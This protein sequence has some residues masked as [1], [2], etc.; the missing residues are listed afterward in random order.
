MEKTISLIELN[1]A[2]GTFYI[3]KMKSGDLIKISKTVSRGDGGVQREESKK[4]VLDIANYCEDPDATFPTPIII[5]VSEKNVLGIRRL[6]E[7]ISSRSVNEREVDTLT[8]VLDSIISLTYDDSKKI[9]EILDGQHRIRGIEKAKQ[10]TLDLPIVVMFDLTEEEKAYV[11]STINSNQTKVDKAL[12]YD[13]FELSTKR[14]PY[15]TC[16]EIARIL[17]LEKNSPFYGNLKMLGK[18]AI[19]WRCCRKG[20]LS[21]I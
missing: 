7:L 16:H 18:K 15:K 9:A 1:Q 11:F 12:I 13:L 5:S 21:L 2:I 20:H 17:N 6:D 4:R 10:Y 14:S 8:D 19:K 3:G